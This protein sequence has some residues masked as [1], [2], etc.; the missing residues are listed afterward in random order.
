[1]KLQELLNAAAPG[2][3][4]DLNPYF[5]YLWTWSGKQIEEGM[6]FQD[7][8]NS[9]LTLQ[10]LLFCNGTAPSIVEDKERSTSSANGK[11]EVRSLTGENT[12]SDGNILFR[13]NSCTD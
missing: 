4:I 7:G 11:Q 12:T 2:K 13:G 8:G 6:V 3:S 10:F 5:E 1:M 9:S